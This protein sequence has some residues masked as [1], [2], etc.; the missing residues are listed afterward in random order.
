M[1]IID[2]AAHVKVETFINIILPVHEVD[3]TALICISSPGDSS[4]WFSVVM[5]AKHPETMEPLLP[6]FHFRNICRECQE[7]EPLKMI[8][9][10]HI[11]DT[12]I[13]DHKDRSK[14]TLHGHICDVVGAGDA[15]IRES[16]GKKK[17]NFSKFKK[18]VF[19][20]IDTRP[21]ASAFP[22][23]LIDDV[24]DVRRRS[25]IQPIDRIEEIV[26]T[27]DPNGGGS[28][29]SA[30][31]IGY[32]N[33]RTESLVVSFFLL[34]KKEKGEKQENMVVYFVMQSSKLIMK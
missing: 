22:Q 10:D 32:L 31:M 8:L 19:L 16:H 25:R 24:F 14:Q 15:H 2:E 23:D 13:A 29:R 26:C 34:H 5:R 20:G 4:N 33:K 11:D 1:I 7:L 27:I 30:V 17:Q 6:A 28:S 21:A 3:G 9:C 12:A 18:I